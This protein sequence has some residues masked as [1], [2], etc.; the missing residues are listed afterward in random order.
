MILHKNLVELDTQWQ[1]WILLIKEIPKHTINDKKNPKLSLGHQSP[2][3]WCLVEIHLKKVGSALFIFIF[4]IWIKINKAFYD[5]FSIYWE[6]C[7][8]FVYF[9]IVEIYILDYYHLLR[10]VDQQNII[11]MI[12]NTWLL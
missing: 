1:F 10:Q 7:Y 12:V 6:F 9:D 3:Y 8:N 5:L 2:Q 4:G 11:S